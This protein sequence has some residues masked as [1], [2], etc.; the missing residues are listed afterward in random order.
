MIA[1]DIKNLKS[2]AKWLMELIKSE[3]VVILR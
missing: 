2:G 3:D 1:L